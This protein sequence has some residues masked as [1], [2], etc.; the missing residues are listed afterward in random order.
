MIRA[1]RWHAAKWL[2]TFRIGCSNYLAYKLNFLLLIIGPTLVF[3]F[4][5][6]NL[7]TSIYA[8]DGVETIQGY[9]LQGMLEYQVWVMILAFLAKSYNSMNLAEDIRL[10]RI[11][12]YLVYPFGFWNFHAANFLA[13]QSIQFGVAALTFAFV[14]LT[15]FIQAAGLVAL[16]K[17]TVLALLVGF[18]WFQ[19]S[20]LIGL[21]AFWLEETWVLRVLF[22]TIAQFFSGAIIP[23]ELYP[24]WVRDL[25]N[26]TPF[27]YLTFV[28]V[29]QFTG[30]YAGNFWL[31]VGTIGLW[32]A[33]S[34]V[35]VNLVWRRGLKLYTAAGM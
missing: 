8:M 35:I 2:Q 1:A 30:Q 22:T 29:K 14:W 25:L 17:G 16:V 24:D 27:P 28:P 10:G 18:L 23:L 11:S 15:G 5:K 34:L 4:I 9:T 7:W 26:W 31:A 33:I 19:I 21:A 13:V 12:S 20:F 6:Y 32:L 3:F